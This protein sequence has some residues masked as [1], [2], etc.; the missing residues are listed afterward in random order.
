MVFSTG[1][2]FIKLL[3]KRVAILYNLI[4]KTEKTKTCMFSNALI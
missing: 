4:E 2:F 3:L 1:E